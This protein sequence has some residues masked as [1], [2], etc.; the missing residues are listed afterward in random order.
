MA[1]PE[2]T[3]ATADPFWTD[4]RT[5][6]SPQSF[7]ESSHGGA[8]SFSQSS[9]IVSAY[10]DDRGAHSWT[11]TRTDSRAKH[12]NVSADWFVSCSYSWTDSRS[13]SRTKHGN[14]CA[15]RCVSCADSESQHIWPDSRSDSWTNPSAESS[16]H[17]GNGRTQSSPDS[18][19]ILFS[20]GNDIGSH[21]RTI[22]RANTGTEHGYSRADFHYSRTNSGAHYR[23]SHTRTNPGTHFYHSRT[24]KIVTG[25]NSWTDYYQPDYWSNG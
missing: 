12:D 24:N 6:F 17:S 21:P 7:P 22:S 15:H 9:G 23:W 4:T 2:P 8:Q 3:G 13:D 10:G 11:D 5:H 25:S 1:T 16:P 19:R 14:P 20:Y 18:N